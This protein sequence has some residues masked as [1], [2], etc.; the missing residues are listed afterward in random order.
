MGHRLVHLTSSTGG[1]R[2]RPRVLLLIDQKWR[3]L[4]G[5]VLLKRTLERE[6]GHRVVAGPFGCEG[7][8]VPLFRPD[9][10][11]V[12]HLLESAKVRLARALRAGGIGIV[13]LPTEGI[14]SLPDVRLFAAGKYTDMSLVDLQLCWN[15]PMRDLIVEHGLLPED[16][17]RVCGVPRFDV[18]A[19]PVRRLVADREEM[20]GRH[21]L[22]ARRPV[23]LLT[24]NFVNAGFVEAN[25]EFFERNSR[26]LGL[27]NVPSYARPSENARK[28][29]ET[30]RLAFDAVERLLADLP[31]ISVALKP[32]PNESQSAY[33][34][35]LGRVSAAHP[36]RVA[37][38][39]QDYIWNVLGTA[40]V[41]IQRS[42]TTAIEAW[43][44]G[45]PTVEFQL[46]PGEYYFSPEH[47]RGSDLVR[48]YEALR[49][50]VG[51][52]VSGAPVPE[53]LSAARRQFIRR[54]VGAVDGGRTRACAA[55]IDR[56]VRARPPT[57]GVA[58]DR[59]W[60]LQAGR[61]VV[62]ELV[63]HPARR[64]AARLRGRLS[65]DALDRLGRSDKRVTF[66]EVRRWARRIDA[67]GIVGPAVA[68]AGCAAAPA[69]QPLE[70]S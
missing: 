41:V 21:G 65:Q 7:V 34:E 39:G 44:H 14:P 56:F 42:C 64:L 12:N 35:W 40:T 63:Y 58:L 49:E 13:A 10:V 33:R 61:S 9:A 28:D 19:E 51:A 1:A 57:A 32:H 20:L 22:D 62:K 31:D 66:A 26:D 67:L 36:G 3:D 11:I 25:V 46:N 60:L 70:R 48:T 59:Y 38:I 37:V 5:H 45:L 15:E 24:S 69:E 6:F 55:E 47:A 29:Y 52:Y 53:A 18:Y 50:R 16:R 30:R 8:L 27:T 4:P 43:L 2:R 68:T 17:V 54:W 23:V